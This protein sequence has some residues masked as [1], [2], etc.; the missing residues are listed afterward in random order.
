QQ[1]MAAHI[2]RDPEPLGR[3]RPGLP[4]AVEQLVMRCLAKRPADRWRSGEELRAR[5]GAAALTAA[6]SVPVAVPA[7]DPVARTFRLTE[8]VCRKLDRAALDPRMIG[9]A[10]QY[11][12]NEVESP[13]LLCFLH[14]TGFDGS[15]F[16]GHL[17]RAEY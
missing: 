2:A 16:D 10:M 5:I 7:P 1:M 13:V 14:G 11:I 12:D 3:V 6:A 15:Q 9:G 4:A 8:E 17:R